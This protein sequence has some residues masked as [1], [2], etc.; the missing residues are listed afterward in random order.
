MQEPVEVPTEPTVTVELADGTRK[1]VP[2]HKAELQFLDEILKQLVRM[3][4]TL[5]GLPDQVRA[6]LP[7]GMQAVGAMLG[8]KVKDSGEG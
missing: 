7:S 1:E 5:E 6:S 4:T 8:R 3:N 2:V